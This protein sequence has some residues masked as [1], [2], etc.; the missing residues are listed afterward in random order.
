MTATRVAVSAVHSIGR[1]AAAPRARRRPRCAA[2]RRGRAARPTGGRR[3]SP[4]ARAGRRSATAR[5]AAA[6]WANVAG[7]GHA[8]AP[9]RSRTRA[10][11]AAGRRLAGAPRSSSAR[12]LRS[13]SRICTESQPVWHAFSFPV[14]VCRGGSNTVPAACPGPPRHARNVARATPGYTGRRPGAGWCNWQH[15]SSGSGSW[16]SSPCPAVGRGWLAWR[17]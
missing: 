1:G 8:S 6:P 5:S 13:T 2:G 10:R 16:G 9:R 3:R 15:A 14:A 7:S 4:R 17:R 12:E 11:T